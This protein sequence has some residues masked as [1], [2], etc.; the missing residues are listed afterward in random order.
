MMLAVAATLASS[1]PI[2]AGPR[3][4]RPLM[5]LPRLA[6]VASNATTHTRGEGNS[7]SAQI[8][9]AIASRIGCAVDPLAARTAQLVVTVASNAING[10]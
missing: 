4:S 8:N 3:R 9:G 6:T 5:P 10:P 2:C 7:S 1:I